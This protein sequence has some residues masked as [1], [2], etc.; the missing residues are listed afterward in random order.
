VANQT[1]PHG[2]N[3]NSAATNRNALF[4]INRP[5]TSAACIAVVYH[6]IISNIYL[7]LYTFPS[8][9]VPYNGILQNT[10]NRM[11]NKWKIEW[12]FIVMY[13]CAWQPYLEVHTSSVQRPPVRCIDVS[14]VTRMAKCKLENCMG[15][16][17]KW[18]PCTIVLEDLLLREICR[19]WFST[20]MRITTTS[21]HTRLCSSDYSSVSISVCPWLITVLY[22][23]HNLR[24][25]N[26]IT[27]PH[28][29]E[30]L[31]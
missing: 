19:W 4:Q 21:L 10:G 9:K 6:L 22:T 28:C 25:W 11:A 15:T 26:R 1:T 23:P 17:I 2:I 18:L 31:R 13:R 5:P 30:V 8:I 29:F 7:T 27:N 24:R 20:L 16:K 12:H 3:N 14:T